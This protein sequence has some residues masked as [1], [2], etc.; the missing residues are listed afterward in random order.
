MLCPKRHCTEKQD[1]SFSNT[2]MFSLLFSSQDQ[3]NN[4]YLSQILNEKDFTFNFL[5]ILQQYL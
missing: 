3:A 5:F 2:D 1:I 4:D